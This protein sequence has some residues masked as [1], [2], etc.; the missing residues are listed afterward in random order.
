MSEFVIPPFSC[1]LIK[2]LDQMI[3]H[4]CPNVGMAMENIQRYAGR[5]D[6]VDILK[7]KMEEQERNESGEKQ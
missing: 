3:P 4:R 6:V 1:D 2:K 7:A 5:R